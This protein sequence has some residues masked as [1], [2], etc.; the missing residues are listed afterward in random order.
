MENVTFHGQLSQ[1]EYTLFLLFDTRRRLVTTSIPLFLLLF[2]F[3]VLMDMVNV[4]SLSWLAVFS[5]SFIL[6][7]VYY[8]LA[9]C[10]L[11]FSAKKSYQTDPYTKRYNTYSINEEF[12]FQQNDRAEAK[13]IWTDMHRVFEFADMFILYL[14]PRRALVLPHRFFESNKDKQAFE[15]ILKQRVNKDQLHLKNHS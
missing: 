14:A 5:W 3:L 6:T 15:E 4:Y 13:H 2:I 1:K 10:T 8:V 12:M 9:I 11:Y 7:L